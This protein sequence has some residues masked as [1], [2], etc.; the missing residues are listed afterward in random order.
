MLQN[1]TA[2]V[3]VNNT[4]VVVL[5][6]RA[7][8]ASWPCDSLPVNLD[9]CMYV[10]MQRKLVHNM[11]LIISYICISRLIELMRPAYSIQWPGK[12]TVFRY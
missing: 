9:V 8:A 6:G 11:F 7:H 5:A 10:C 4:P 2:L 3:A 1:F 12:D